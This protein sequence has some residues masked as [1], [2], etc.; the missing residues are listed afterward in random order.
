MAFEITEEQAARMR[1][2]VTDYVTLCYKYNVCIHT[3]GGQDEV[4]SYPRELLRDKE[5][6]SMLDWR[7]D[8]LDWIKKRSEV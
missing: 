8:Q 1:K 7:Q 3:D 5:F 2:F 6:M 4:F